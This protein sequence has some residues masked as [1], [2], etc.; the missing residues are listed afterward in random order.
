[1]ALWQ[2]L[3][4]SRI[5]SKIGGFCATESPPVTC[6]CDPDVLFR[7][8]PHVAKRNKV[9]AKNAVTFAIDPAERVTLR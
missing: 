1:M 2:D 6:R 7:K 4:A 5:T 3:S 9:F 8:L